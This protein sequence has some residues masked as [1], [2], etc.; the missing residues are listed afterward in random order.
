A[1]NY[2]GQGH[3][4]LLAESDEGPA[5]GEP[6][7]Q[8]QPQPLSLHFSGSAEEQSEGV[9][10][11]EDNGD[12]EERDGS[13]RIHGEGSLVELR[14]LLR[15]A[16]EGVAED[17][18]EQDLLPKTDTYYGGAHQSV[19]TSWVAHAARRS[20]RRQSK[21]ENKVPK[22]DQKAPHPAHVGSGPGSIP[23]AMA[24]KGLPKVRK[25]KK[26]RK[27]KVVKF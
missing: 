20:I 26:P 7:P 5:L 15:A 21:N 4:G 18:R 9:K 12:D 11:S 14:R 27:S 25:G 19:D 13:S 1:A 6:Q 22:E 8:P 24:K 2:S 16:D 17:E 3:S 23:T 10:P